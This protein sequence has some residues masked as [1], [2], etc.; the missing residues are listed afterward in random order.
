LHMHL[1]LWC[2]A[3]LPRPLTCFLRAAS[4]AAARASS[5][6]LFC[7]S[8]F[9]RASSCKQQAHQQMTHGASNNFAY[10][11]L[12]AICYRMCLARC[13]RACATTKVQ[14]QLHNQEVSMPCKQDSK[15]IGSPVAVLNPPGQQALVPLP[16]SVDMHSVRTCLRR[17]AS[18][19]AA[20]ASSAF[21]FCSSLAFAA[22]SALAR[23]SS[24]KHPSAA[25]HD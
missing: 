25:A 22:A 3:M 4:A 16:T 5:A 9:A 11:D 2:C 13:A 1:V 6:L 8:A 20:R 19:A 18:A 21:L 15:T 24:C 23:V 12:D 10:S 7:S 17:A 14:Q